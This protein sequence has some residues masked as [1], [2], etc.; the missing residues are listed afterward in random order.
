MS[1][2][3]IKFKVQ[4]PVTVEPDEV[5]YVSYCPALDLFSQ[6]PSEK[7]ATKNIVDAIQLFLESCFIRGTL[8]RVL[9]DCGF[10]M[11]EKVVSTR[12]ER[13]IKDQHMKMVNVP[14]SRLVTREQAHA[15]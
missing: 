12:R 4:V 2:N 7:E 13:P 15:G 10:E 14:L 8:E 1:Q 5:G 6:G 3:W 9:K 11:E